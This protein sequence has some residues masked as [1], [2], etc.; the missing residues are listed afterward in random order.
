M[1]AM[2][3]I[4]TIRN[5]RNNHDKS[6]NHIAEELEINW[7]TAKKYADEDLLPEPKIRKKTGMM[8]VE[9]WGGI[10]ALW[11]SE[12]SK[13]PKKK[14]RTI[15]FMTKELKNQGFPDP[16]ARFVILLGTGKPLTTL[17]P[18]KIKVL[19]AWNIL[20]RKRSWISV[21]WRFAMKEPL[22]MSKHS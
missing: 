16:I 12:D 18:M 19:S 7:R 17:K 1:P 21:P 14:R 6:I 5:L 15:D 10:V 8:Y 22:R 20:R 13:L 11:L 2:T 3:D 4:N 9:H